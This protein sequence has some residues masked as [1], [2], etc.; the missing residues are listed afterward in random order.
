MIQWMLAIWSLVPLPF[1]NPAWTSGN[2]QLL[3][4]GLENFEYYFASVWDNCNCAV[5]WIF[6]ALP[7]L[8]LEWKL[9]FS[10]PEATAEFFKLAGILSVAPYQHHLLG[11]ESS[12]GIPSPPLVLFRVTLPKA[13]LTSHSR[14][15]GSTWVIIPPWS[16]RSWRPFLYSSS[17]YSCCLLISSASVRPIPFLSFIVLI[18]AWSVPLVSLIF[19]KRSLGFPILL[20]LHVALY[21]LVAHYAWWRPHLCGW[22]GFVQAQWG[23]NQSHPSQHFPDRLDHGTCTPHKKLTFFRQIWE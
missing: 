8:R 3:K 17:V 12:T 13:H 19:L 16:S 18:F 9:T 10:S 1:L 23:S 14:M 2:S 20:F 7:F 4:P 21:E 11:F 5:V 6:W 22:C 15:S